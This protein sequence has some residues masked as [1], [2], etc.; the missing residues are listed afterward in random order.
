MRKLSSN[1]YTRR[2]RRLCRLDLYFFLKPKE[3]S[4]FIYTLLV[5]LFVCC[6][7][8]INVKTPEPIG[9][10]LCVG[11]HMSP[12]KVNEWS[13]FQKFA[14]KKIQFLFNFENPRFLKI[15]SAKFFLLLHNVYKEKMLNLIALQF[16][17]IY[18]YL[19]FFFIYH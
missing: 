2:T 6:L 11:P 18:K 10:N 5:F 1:Y 19:L 12:E 17:Q 13:K 15:K 14:T 4:I 9:P 3:S 8:T 16:R 7:Y